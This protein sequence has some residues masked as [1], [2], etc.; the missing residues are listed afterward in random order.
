VVDASDRHLPARAREILQ[1]YLANPRTAD[2]LEGITEWR[3]LDDFVQRRV[4]ETRQAL[5][6]LVERGFLMRTVGR[7][8][9][10]VYRL[11]QQTL[12]DAARLIRDAEPP[13]NR[14]PNE[15]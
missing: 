9:P 5:E 8:A 10:P 15:D 7:A 4:E 13:P 14:T 2:S 11:N 6:W 12:A 1:H 3:L